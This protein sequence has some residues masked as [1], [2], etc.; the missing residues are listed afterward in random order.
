MFLTFFDTSKTERAK[1]FPSFSDKHHAIQEDMGGHGVAVKVHQV[2]S[3]SDS[4]TGMPNPQF[5]T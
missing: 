1:E 2:K 5:T 4:W 3:H